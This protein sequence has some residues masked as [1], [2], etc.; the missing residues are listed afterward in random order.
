MYVSIV[1]DLIGLAVISLMLVYGLAF[2][3]QQGQGAQWVTDRL[4]RP[5][6]AAPFLLIGHLFTGVG[7]WIRGH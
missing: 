5:V 1:P 6:I 3:I 2:L 7:R 4:V